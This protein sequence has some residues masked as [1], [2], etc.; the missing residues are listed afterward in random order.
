MA[1]SNL[2]Q[3]EKASEL[4]VKLLKEKVVNSGL[5]MG[6]PMHNGASFG[7]GFR[8]VLEWPSLGENIN[9]GPH[10]QMTRWNF[11]ERHFMLID[12]LGFSFIP[13]VT[14][15]LLLSPPLKS[16]PT[17]LFSLYK[18]S[19]EKCLQSS[20]HHRSSPCMSVSPEPR[21]ERRYAAIVVS[22]ETASMSLL[23][24][25]RRK[26]C[27]KDIFAIMDFNVELNCSFGKFETIFN[28]VIPCT[29]KVFY[30]MLKSFFPK[31]S[32][33]SFRASYAIPGHPSHPIKS[34]MDMEY[35]F[36][37]LTLIEYKM[38]HVNIDADV[39]DISL[40]S[41]EVITIDPSVVPKPE[42]DI[43]NLR[44]K[45]PGARLHDEKDKLIKIFNK[46]AYAYKPFSFNRYITELVAEGKDPVEEF[47]RY[48]QPM[49][50][51]NAFFP[52][53]SLNIAE[54][55][56]LWIVAKR[57]LPITQ[58]VNGIRAKMLSLTREHRC[59]SKNTLEGR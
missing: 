21:S 57:Q 17:S 38:V 7:I 58:L 10:V 13:P 59:K 50:W 42:F 14:K 4:F 55:F 29:F 30:D 47:L 45:F 1:R 49:H 6:G 43:N 18:P 12:E 16:T 44:A 26:N 27:L 36:A 54:S 11:E 19:P 8:L 24:P 41:D 51:A 32:N 56:N 20:I 37:T 23:A 2:D 46:C 39:V 5:G 40:S 35:M 33:S 34:D 25:Y 28:I 15:R 31:L 9:S 3:K 22:L 53:Q 48:L 52:G